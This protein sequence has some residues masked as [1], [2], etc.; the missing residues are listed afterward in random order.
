MQLGLRL[1]AMTQ[2]ASAV[3]AN[4][5]QY[6]ITPIDLHAH[7]YQVVLNIPQPKAMQSLSLPVWIPGSY[8]VREFSKS[9]QGLGASQSGQLV[10]IQQQNK[11]TWV[12]DC[13][14]GEPLTLSYQICAHDSSVRTA[15]LDSQRGFFNG[16]SVFLRVHGSEALL[17]VLHVEPPAQQ[18]HWQLATGLTAAQPTPKALAATTPAAT[19]SWWTA[20]W[21]W[22]HSGVPSSWPM[23]C[24]TALW[25]PGRRPVLMVR[26]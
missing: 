5:I 21:R 25:W 12:V 26:G 6:T 7:L 19:T 22:A 10:D 18:P 8:L 24:H 23:A 1:Q 2:S 16:T 20:R 11:N 13:S 4:A 17:Q 15:W 14:A 9:L 3:A